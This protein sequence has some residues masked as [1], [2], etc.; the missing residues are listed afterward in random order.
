MAFLKIKNVLFMNYQSV[1]DTVTTSSTTNWKA[2]LFS[3]LHSLL[4]LS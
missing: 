3:V 4:H 1:N 2:L